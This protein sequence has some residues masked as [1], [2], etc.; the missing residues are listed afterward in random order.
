[1]QQKQAKDK[2]AKP[3]E[4]KVE[5]KKEQKPKDTKKEKEVEDEP[6]ETELAL[7]QE[8][9]SKDPFEAFPKGLVLHCLVTFCTLNCIFC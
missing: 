6:D 8:P 4:K 5:K 1:M 2:S 7:A 3:N 9:K